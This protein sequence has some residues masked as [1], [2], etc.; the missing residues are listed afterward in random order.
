MEEAVIYKL[1]Y[2]PLVAK[3][4]EDIPE[5][6]KSRIRKAIEQRIGVDPVKAGRPLQKSLVGHRKMRVGDYRVIY[7]VKGNTIIILKIGHRREVYERAESR[8]G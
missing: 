4:I 6:I 7:R 3:D 8:I 2:H 5:N 1:L